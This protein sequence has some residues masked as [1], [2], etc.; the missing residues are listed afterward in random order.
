MK[1]LL[2]GNPS[3]KLLKKKHRGFRRSKYLPYTCALYCAVLA[4]VSFLGYQT[5][6]VVEPKPVV[7]S[8]PSFSER[9]T[10]ARYLSNTTSNGSI[11]PTPAPCEDPNGTFP[12]TYCDN[13]TIRFGSLY[14]NDLFSMAELRSG[15]VILHILLMIQT[16]FGLAMICDAYFENALESICEKLDLTDDVAGATFMA[17]GGSAP[18]LF[19]SFMGAFVALN[20][21]G[22]GTIVGSAVF[23]VLFV[24]ALCAFMAPGLGLTWWPLCRD[25]IYYCFSIIVLVVVVIDSKVQWYEGLILLFCYILYVTV[26]KFNHQ[27]EKWTTRKVHEDLTRKK[28]KYQ[29]LMTHIVDSY[30]FMFAIYMV[31]FFNIGITFIDLGSNPTTTATTT[32][33]SSTT[34]TAANSNSWIGIANDVC[35]IIFIVEY[36]AK[37]YAFGIFGYWTDALNAFD[38]VLVFLI[39]VEYALSSGNMIAIFRGAKVFR[40]MKIARILRVVR[41]WRMLHKDYESV[42]VQTESDPSKILPVPENGKIVSITTRRG[43]KLDQRQSLADVSSDEL[44]GASTTHGNQIAPAPNGDFS[45]NSKES[46]SLEEKRD[47]KMEKG[48]STEDDDSDD[49]D[50]DDDGPVPNPLFDIPA[51]E[52][53]DPDEEGNAVMKPLTSWIV[54]VLWWIFTAPLAF[55][56]WCT[57]P[58]LNLEKNEE[59][60]MATFGISI[61][62]ITILSFGMVWMAEIFGFV[63]GIDPPV[64]GVTILA[65]GTSIPDALSSIAV[66]VR[67]HGD[68]AVSSSVGSNIF[69]ILIG[70]PVPWTL[71]TLVSGTY[72]PIL[73]DNIS[74]LILTLFIMVAAV[75]CIIHVSGWALT[76]R[77]GYA[78]LFLYL[79][80]VAEALLLEYKIIQL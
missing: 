80:F 1:L 2:P 37:S 24:I 16:F 10:V 51:R 20:D 79:I 55:I 4:G 68:M 48:V 29:E 3:K 31:I 39:I 36:I 41:L 65:A 67:G 28:S 15:A 72:V 21:V 66:A 40:F 23:N 12:H 45:K 11:A 42:A 18:E 14:P 64:M 46:S 8:F 52:E 32:N 77:L 27:L 47:D 35:S 49:D 75:I 26:M 50:D 17:A 25:C 56:I 54:E 58:D 53:D 6:V 59:L 71:K 74:I 60:Y 9:P 70:L 30:L 19:T 73:S 61:I 13:K 38:G 22:I 44:R 7:H 34:S 62:W 63:A 78:M 5:N 43:S 76:K 57:V 69:D 33:S